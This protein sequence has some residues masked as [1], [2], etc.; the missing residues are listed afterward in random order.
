M[1]DGTTK[2]I[3][4]VKVGELVKT[5]DELKGVYTVSPVTKAQHHEKRAQVLFTFTFANGKSVTSN[6]VHLI[7]VVDFGRYLS[8]EAIYHTWR[9][10]QKL[11]LLGDNGKPTEISFIER[12]EAEVETFNIHVKSPYDTDN[13]TGRY[14][15]NYFADGVMV[16]NIKN[17]SGN[18]G[19]VDASPNTDCT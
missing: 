11:M 16:H 2:N 18:I 15:H 13:S 10:G 17:D 4:D 7:Y 14:G 19:C 1:G 12:S 9:P 5:Y 3:Q 6:D 8:A